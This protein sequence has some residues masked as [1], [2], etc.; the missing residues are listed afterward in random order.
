MSQKYTCSPERLEEKI[1]TF[2]QFGDTGN[3]GIT[4]LSLSKEALTA[5]K[6]FIQRCEA[7]GMTVK[8]DDMANIYATLPGTEEGMPAILS[9]SHMDSVI[10]G[11]N[12]DG[13]LGVLSA[14]E[15]VETI[16]AEK[17]PHKHPITVVVWTNE[18]GARFDPAMMSSGV[19]T[20][21][22]KK[23][24]MLQSTDVEGC[25]FGEALK[26]SGYAGAE[27]NR[28]SPWTTKALVELH[29]E[30]GPVLDDEHVDIGVVRGVMGM[31][32]YEF[33]LIGQADHVGTT[34][35]KYRKD[36]LL[37]A[38][39]VILMLHEKLDKLNPTLVYT[40]GRITAEPN[41]HTVIPDKVQFTLD[42]RHE[43]P[44]VIQQVVDAIHS[45]PEM[46]AECPLTY[47]EAWARNT[48]EFHPTYVDYVEKAAES[49]GYSSRRMYS[50]AGHDAQYVAE[51]V[52]TTMIFV[53]SIDGHSHC[54]KEYTPLENCVKGVNVLLQTLLDI[55]N[56]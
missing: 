4:R 35:M 15:A 18:E 55:D 3:G 7:L 22:F 42:A 49:F 30:Q 28:M 19:I 24:D 47:K 40:T 20:G 10:Q 9:G 33:T 6:E 12:Y 50:G 31:V 26:A 44:A 53:P 54:E 43:D 52:P 38:S 11:G 48:V 32:N 37:A 51:V 36:A 34:P 46:V 29:A 8:T 1:K 45:L 2:S 25:T 5:R 16:V 41:I 27:E 17:I 23:E 13:I 21:K 14:L 56:E 39:Q